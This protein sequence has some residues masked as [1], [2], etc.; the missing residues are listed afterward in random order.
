MVNMVDVN[1]F[2][3]DDRGYELWMIR[4]RRGWV[5]NAYRSVAPLNRTPNLCCLLEAPSLLELFR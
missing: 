5:L 2:V 1:R 3:D 4:N